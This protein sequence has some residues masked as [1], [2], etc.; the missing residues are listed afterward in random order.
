MKEL[1][2][3]IVAVYRAA[4]GAYPSSPPYHPSEQYPEY[5]FRRLSAKPNFAYEAVRG[6][7]RL[8][9]LDAE[10]FGT[11]S[12]N[13]LA[14]IISAGDMVV[15]KPNMV[16]DFHEEVQSGTEALIT[17]ASVVRAV[18]D[19]VYLA[20]GKKGRVVIADSPQNDADWDGLWRAF[21]FDSLL[22]SYKELAPEFEIDIYD[23]RK[24]AVVSRNGVVI[25][26]YQRPGDPLGYSTIDVGED[27]EFEGVPERFGKFYGS[28]YDVSQTNRHHQHARHEYNIANTFLTADV[29]V[30][31]PK[32]KTHK[33]SG[34]TAWIKS[35]IG[36]CGDK[37]W[38]PHHT[39]GSPG[40]GGDQF[41]EDNLKRKTEQ[42]LTAGVKSVV[43]R[44]GTVGGLLGSVLR[45]SGTYVF[46]DTNKDTVRSGNW[47]GNDTI[48]RTV[49]D[50]HKCWVYADKAGVLRLTPQRRFICIVDS[51]VAGEGNGP[52]AP[53]P[54]AAGVCIV[55]FD[56]IATDTT[57]A[58]LMGFDPEKLPILTR[59]KSTKRFPL[60]RVA[61]DE[62]SV[63]SN[64]RSWNGGVKEISETLE[65]KPH[66]G[67]KG[68]IEAPSD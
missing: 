8:A 53:D 55:G 61:Q 50:L 52:L 33:K 37:N 67:W 11:A 16:R 47:H 27:S 18:V 10:R 41:A 54:K 39:Q 64:F 44:T 14:D 59:A 15:I 2:K 45:K 42:R 3:N 29:I 6:A 28:E 17:H 49:L 57:C 24:E 36:I 1:L 12:W 4:E 31:V 68:H 40:G 66:F 30:N 23:V 60:G 62:I 7:L 13:P 26:R 25:K 43:K 56:P 38:L 21:R 20:L 46:G 9:G 19:Y 48:W 51:I 58:V 32:L 22:A 65:F 63:V 35:V 34:I 5:P